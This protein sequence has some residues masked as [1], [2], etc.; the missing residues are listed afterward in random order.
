M[1]SWCIRGTVKGVVYTRKQ[2]LRHIEEDLQ[3]EDA[4]VIVSEAPEIH[5][6]FKTGKATKV[7]EEYIRQ[8]LRGK[9]K[10]E[11]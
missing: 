1:L 4:V 6:M 5:Q 9:D 7:I 11:S 3:Q 10:D 2:V 8:V